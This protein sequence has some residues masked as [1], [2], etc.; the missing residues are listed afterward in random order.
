MTW[1]MSVSNKVT[2]REAM[3]VERRKRFVGQLFTS[4]RGS[5]LCFMKELQA[6]TRKCGLAGWPASI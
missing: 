4:G 2:P 3:L 5:W 1:S 6:C